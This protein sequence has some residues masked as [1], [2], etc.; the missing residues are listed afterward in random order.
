MASY[1]MAMTILGTLIPSFLRELSLDATQAGSLF[2]W[3]NAGA[4]A[5]TGLAGIVFDRHGPRWVLGVAQF[6]MAAGI[7]ATAVAGG[8]L[9]LALAFLLLGVGG[10][11]TNLGANALVALRAPGHEGASLNRL[12]LFYGVG[13]FA[14]PFLAAA[15]LPAWGWRAF[16]AGAALAALLPPLA[17]LAL[18]P[19]PGR[20]AAA[21]AISGL[22]I[23]P[24]FRHARL[25]WLGVLLL[26][27]AGNEMIVGGWLTTY[28]VRE[29][30]TSETAAALWLG[31]FWATLIAGRGLGAVALRRWSAVRLVLV[32]ALASSALVGCF[33]LGSGPAALV[34]IL[35][36]G[37]A[38]S[39]I[40]PTVFAQGIAVLPARPGTVL[41]I[42][43]TAALLGSMTLPWAAGWL[44]ETAGP[45]A[46]I[47]LAAVG[48]LVVTGAQVLA[49][50]QPL[51]AGGIAPEG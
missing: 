42:L 14:L 41:G 5:A 51:R 47:L 29:T 28:L 33:T 22:D 4:L 16:L 8:Y 36:A 35:L 50:R 39:P 10:G 43:M 3:L 40:F 26:F 1:G 30:E 44:M 49:S 17:L 46:A 21:G 27:E 18:P 12:G 20:P 9:P 38:M 19:E 45:R 7:L 48:F 15:L 6:T 23:G 34:C 37:F 11:G 2:F 24:A 25:L 31:L 32:S 13:S